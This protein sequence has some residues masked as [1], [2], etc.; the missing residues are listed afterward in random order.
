[1]KCPKCKHEGFA[2]V[3][4]LARNVYDYQKRNAAIFGC[5]N[6]DCGYT[7]VIK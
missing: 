4:P 1:M 3:K 6:E 2:I 7:E 5:K